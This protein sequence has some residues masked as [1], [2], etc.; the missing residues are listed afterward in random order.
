MPRAEIPGYYFDET[1]NKYFKITN[2]SLIGNSKYHS[3]KI[4]S[5]KR[6]IN[7]D[8]VKKKSKLNTLVVN[9]MNLKTRLDVINVKLGSA[10]FLKD[11]SYLRFEVLRRYQ[12]PLKNLQFGNVEVFG[13]INDGLL[14]KERD[15]SLKVVSLKNFLQSNMHLHLII[16]DSRIEDYY[17]RLYRIDSQLKTPKITNCAVH[18]ETVFRT[19]VLKEENLASRA[20]FIQLDSL[21]ENGSRTDL[22]INLLRS[23]DQLLSSDA[24]NV[25]L[26]VFGIGIFNFSSNTYDSTSF[27]GT[28]L[29]ITCSELIANCL[30]IASDRGDLIRIKLEGSGEINALNYFSVREG[31]SI[32]CVKSIANKI[33][34][35]TKTSIFILDDTL[36]LKR[37][38]N[39][40]DQIQK[41]YVIDSNNAV[42]VGLRK[43]SLL[44][45]IDS[46]QQ[47][48]K[49]LYFNDNITNQY[50]IIFLGNLIV[51]ESN[52]LI[53]VY[54]LT[55][56]QFFKF[57]LNLQSNERL[58]NI[59]TI[60]DAFIVFQVNGTFTRFIVYRI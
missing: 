56:L 23:A 12:G 31:V 41:I 34:L 33:F 1:R 21:S 26:K 51:N 45:L 38:V 15:L 49:L 2:G 30:L 4:Q 7:N 40:N 48:K 10:L 19:I 18:S 36:R 25:L 27:R 37:K 58:S 11:I 20:N 8:A 43:I 17:Q 59:F 9:S 47:F 46:Q 44:Q 24:K 54:N 16:R 53:L 13:S 5:K 6:R 29:S 55:S 22:T 57:C 60:E 52:S 50:S 42:I 14:V 39:Y 28:N 35:A 32:V 3:N